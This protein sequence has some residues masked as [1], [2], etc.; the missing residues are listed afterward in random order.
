MDLPDNPDL[1]AELEAF[2]SEPK[3]DKSAD[4]TAQIARQSGV[5]AL[6]LVTHD[7]SSVRSEF[8]PSVY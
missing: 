8:R 7:L 2:H 1:I 6:C 4:Y 3:F 5:H